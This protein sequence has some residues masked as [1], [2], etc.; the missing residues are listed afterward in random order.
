MPFPFNKFRKARVDTGLSREDFADR[1]GVDK[2]TLEALEQ[3]RRLNPTQD[4][5]ELLCNALGVGCDFFFGPDIE[6][7]AK[8][9]GRGRPPGP[10]KPKRP[11]GR[12][13]KSS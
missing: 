10:G 6:P 7:P 5:I 3:G 12:P 13:R 11:R 2:R 8:P 4:T 1:Y 9:P